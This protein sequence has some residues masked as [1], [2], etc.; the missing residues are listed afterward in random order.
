MTAASSRR[1][2]VTCLGLGAAI[3]LTAEAQP[4]E[5]PTEVPVEPYHGWVTIGA[6]SATRPGLLMVSASYSFGRRSLGQLGASLAADWGREDF[7]EVHLGVGR[8]TFTRPLLAAAFV[9]PSLARVTTV[10]DP[11]SPTTATT[12]Y[13]PGV[14]GNVQVIAVALPEIGLGL[15]AFGHVNTVRS[16]AGVR[17]VLYLGNDRW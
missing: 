7:S 15:D 11:D 13:V 12:R 4:V 3:A 14:F 16:L 8:R 17:L 9:G 2:L 5:A 1:R 6:G 10:D